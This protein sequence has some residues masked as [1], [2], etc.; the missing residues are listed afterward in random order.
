MAHGLD[1]LRTHDYEVRR[2]RCIFLNSVPKIMD[3]SSSQSFSLPVWD[4]GIYAE[5]NQLKGRDD[6]RAASS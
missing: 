6:R 5:G 3:M 2:A 4:F 1:V